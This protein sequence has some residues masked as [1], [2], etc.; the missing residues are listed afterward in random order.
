MSNS[1][2]NEGVRL[3]LLRHAEVDEAYHATFGGK[4]DMGLSTRGHRQAAS[5]AEYLR[6]HEFDAVYS[7]PMKRVRETMA[8][9][10]EAHAH[11]EHAIEHDL[12][13]VDFGAWT[14]LTWNAVL[15]HHGVHAFDWLDHLEAGSIPDAESGAVFRS[16]VE[17]CIRGIV[18]RHAGQSVVIACH[19]G[20][21]RMILSILLDL[22]LSKT[23]HFDIEYASVSRVDHRPGKT[24][25]QMLNFT[26][27]RD[28]R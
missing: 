9:F 13:E 15:E 26:P 5:L 19:G 17:P 1:A 2:Q 10:T 18:D 21:I 14:G 23:C 20:V 27:W 25:I 24:E 12:R 11:H 4:I 28:L 8:P 6:T 7:S 22:P 3:F 16:R